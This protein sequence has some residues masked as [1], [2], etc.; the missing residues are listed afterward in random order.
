MAGFAV[1]IKLNMK[2]PCPCCRS[3]TLD[4]RADD[5]IC[6]VCF[7]HDDGQDDDEAER[8]WGGPNGSLS[9]TQARVNYKAF[10]ACD[11]RF[12]PNVSAPKPEEVRNV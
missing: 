8:V 10:G 5:E 12:L 3:L 11:K 2:V 7:W 1:Y 6:K 9:L 4:K